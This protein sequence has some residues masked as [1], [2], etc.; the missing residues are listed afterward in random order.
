LRSFKVSEIIYYKVNV[1]PELA[2]MLPRL[3][4]SGFGDIDQCDLPT[5]LR[6][7]DRVPSRASREV[8]RVSSVRKQR[9]N[10]PRER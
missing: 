2:G 7:P 9:H 1:G 3:F 10:V 4:D 8:K 6:Q 5:L